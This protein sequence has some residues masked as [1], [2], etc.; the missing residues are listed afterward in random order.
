MAAIN[1]DASQFLTLVAQQF[2]RRHFPDQDTLPVY[3]ENGGL[4]SPPSQV[5]KLPSEVQVMV[6]SNAKNFAH[7]LQLTRFLD[8]P[9][10]DED[11]ESRRKV[12]IE[13]SAQN[14]LVRLNKPLGYVQS[15]SEQ[16]L[17]Q[18]FQ[19]AF[20]R[21]ENDVRHDDR[22]EII[23]LSIRLQPA[24]DKL[25][26]TF[27]HLKYKTEF[28]VS[29]ILNHL[30]AKIVLTYIS[31][32]V[33]QWAQPRIYALLSQTVIPRG[34]NFLINNAHIHV[35]YVVSGGVALVQ[36]AYFH[37]W[38]ASFTFFIAKCISG[39]IHPLVHRIVVIVEGVAFFPSRVIEWLVMSPFSLF[40]S[41]WSMHSSLAKSLDTSKD[42]SRS[43]FLEVGGMKA[44]RAW[45]ELMQE[46][47]KANL[48][49]AQTA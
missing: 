33:A 36:F 48:V 21:V 5:D 13:I 29:R 20:N 7:W 4:F 46:G 47:M 27:R 31:Y 9:L 1:R 14:L 6:Q 42:A 45:M 28:V 3:K 23:T 40:T 12:A 8:A 11:A 15:Y 44:H 16:L 49:V 2:D 37:Y 30:G 25:P 26:L 10:E 41:S 18:V 34:V 32:R 43:A 19:D 38:K 22:E 24:L 39:K 35:I 17:T